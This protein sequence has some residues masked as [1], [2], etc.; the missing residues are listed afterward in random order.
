MTIPNSVTSIGESAFSNNKLT[1]VTIPNRVTE[2][3]RWAFSNN[4]LSSISIGGNVSLGGYFSAFD[5]GFD[6]YYK[7]K[8]KKAGTY[9]YN[10]RKWSKQ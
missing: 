10:G 4:Q 3:G 2:I 5:Y 6:E 9:T 8:G 7:N 1:S